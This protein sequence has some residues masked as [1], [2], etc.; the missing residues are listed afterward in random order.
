[1]EDQGYYMAMLAKSLAECTSTA[2][3]ET[4]ATSP[5]FRSFG[6]FVPRPAGDLS[7]PPGDVGL[8]S[9][10]NVLPDS[11]T[12]HRPVVTTVRAGSHGPGTKLVSLKRRNFKAIRRQGL[13]GALN[14]TD[15]SKVYNI[16][17]VDAV[18]DYISAGIVSALNVIAPEK[19][20]RVKKGPNLYLMGETLEAMKKRDPA[21]GRRYRILRNEVSRLIRRDKQDGNL[22]SLKKASKDPKVLWSLADQALGKD[23]P[24]LPATIT[25]ANGPTTTPMEAAEV[26]NK[27]FVDKV[28][29]LRKKALLPRADTHITAT[30]SPMSRQSLPQPRE[31]APEVP[32]EAPDVAGEVPHFRQDTGQVSQEVGN[33]AQEVNDVR[34]EVNNVRQGPADDNVTSGRYVHVLKL[35]FKFANAKKTTKTIRGLNNTEALGVDNIPTSVLKKG[36]E[37]LSGPVAH[38]INLILSEGKVPAQFKIGRV[39]PIHKGKGKP[40]KDPASYRPVSILPALSKVIETYVKEDLEDHLRKVNG[41]PG[42]QYGFRPKRSCTSALAHAQAGWLLGAAKGQVVGLMAFDLSGRTLTFLHFSSRIFFY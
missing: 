15:W 39:H 32:E 3:L 12:D 25:S 30:S 16:K 2:G 1:M 28:D 40:R 14:L 29:D 33:I 4:H 9:E 24:S 41:L 18:L 11:T 5:T 10:S 23:C 37:V 6:N 34:Q 36:V 21:T 13:E 42:S 7:R 22:L 8:I 19:E 26:M 27:F 31:D 20:I 35:F 38:L 17:D